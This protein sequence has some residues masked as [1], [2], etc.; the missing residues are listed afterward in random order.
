MV[1]PVYF[2]EP[3]ESCGVIGVDLKN[4]LFKYVGLVGKEVESQLVV[5]AH[6]VRKRKSRVYRSCYQLCVALRVLL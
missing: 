5:K 2:T 4:V 1:C 6:W 3:K